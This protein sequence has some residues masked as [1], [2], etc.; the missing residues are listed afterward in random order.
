MNQSNEIDLRD[1]IVQSPSRN[2]RAGLLGGFAIFTPF[3]L[4]GFNSW[5]GHQFFPNNNLVGNIT[6]YM[7]LFG[8]IPLIGIAVEKYFLVR[9]ATT[10][11]FVTQDTVRSLLGKI[12]I[13]VPY[14]P[15]THI[16]F[17]WERRL[18]VNNIIVEDAAIDF[19]FTIQRP[20]GTLYG[21]GSYRMR[22]DPNNPVAFLSSAA[23]VGE[24][25][26]DLIIADIQKFFKAE[27]ALEATGM[28]GEVNNYLKREYIG[29]EKEIEDANGVTKKEFIPKVSDVEE[30]NG[31]NISDVTVSEILPDN[32]LRRTLNGISEARG[33]QQ[34]VLILLGMNTQE[35]VNEALKAG[36]LS[37]DDVKKA[38]ENFLAIS[39]NMDNMK[40]ERREFDIN[41]R[42]LSDE[43]VSALT[44]LA[45]TPAAQAA[46]TAA[47]S[48]KGGGGSKQGRKK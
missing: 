17:P 26:R 10:G 18:A 40:I 13:N 6:W 36:T 9:N 15:G 30:R 3:V 23:A 35:E 20:D 16:S 12:D 29:E 43:A 5:L 4:A 19:L 8:S 39:G 41:I 11:M 44:E 34:G 46:A 37:Q 33:V 25:V 47:A 1:T 31:V 48:G 2:S 28:I 24:E 7:G 21:K 38:R 22:P 27:S 45:K 42:G 14:G 32:D